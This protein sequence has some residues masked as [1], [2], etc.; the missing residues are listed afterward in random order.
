MVFTEV[1]PLTFSYVLVCLQ[2]RVVMTKIFKESKVLA[3]VDQ[4]WWQILYSF[5]IFENFLTDG[6]GCLSTAVTE[7][8]S[9]GVV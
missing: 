1:Q 9:V 6:S 8:Y 2:E 4:P 5:T 7:V 3:T